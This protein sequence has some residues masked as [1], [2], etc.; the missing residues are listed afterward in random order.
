V[1]RCGGVFFLGVY[2]R[3]K[4]QRSQGESGRD[5]ADG[6]AKSGAGSKMMRH[7]L[8]PQNVSGDTAKGYSILKLDGG[9]ARWVIGPVQSG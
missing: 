6:T 4:Q 8:T 1:R 2:Q 7:G 5:E 3:R 9:E